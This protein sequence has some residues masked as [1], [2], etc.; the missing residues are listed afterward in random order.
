MLESL[1]KL[2]FKSFFNAVLNVPV[3]AWGPTEWGTVAASVLLFVGFAYAFVRLQT[4]VTKSKRRK[5]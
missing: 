5:R 2:S 4:K 3:D 1:L